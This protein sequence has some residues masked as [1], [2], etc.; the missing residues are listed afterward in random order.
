MQRAEGR[1]N[2]TEMFISQLTGNDCVDVRF[3]EGIAG[4]PC[5][6]SAIRSR[7]FVFAFVDDVPISRHS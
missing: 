5:G 6:I 1:V 4:V 7:A 3:E 2:Q